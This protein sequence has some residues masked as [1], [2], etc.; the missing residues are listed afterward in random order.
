MATVD[1][2]K[3][4]PYHHTQERSFEELCY[5]IAKGLYGSEGTFTSVDDT[6]GGD[7]VEF[8]L[9]LPNGDDWGW[10]AKFYNPEPRLSVRNRK[11]SIKDSLEESC[12]KHLNLKKWIL[13][14]PTNFTTAEQA[15]FK[16]TLLKCVPDGMQVKLEHWQES[17]F[18]DWL[19]QPRFSGKRHYFFGE[20]VLTLDWCQIQ[21]E[22]QLKT[23]GDKFNPLLHT[24]SDVDDA[25]HQFLGD[26]AFIENFSHQIQELDN[27]LKK[28]TQAVAELN[29]FDPHQIQLNDEK[30]ELLVAVI[31]LNESLS[32]AV[33]YLQHAH[34]LLQEHK[35]EEIQQSDWNP[36]YDQMDK[37]YKAYGYTS[38]AFDIDAIPYTGR[39]EE[40]SSVL[41][42]ARHIIVAPHY[43]AAT[44]MDSWRDVR[45]RLDSINTPDLHVLGHAGVGKTHI[46]SHICQE[47]IDAGL[48]ALLL[49]GGSFTSDQP[50]TQQLRTILDIPPTYS[51][52]DFLKSMATFAEAYHTR[53]PLIIDGLNEAT[54]NGKFSSVWKQ[55]LES[56]A[57][58]I[59]Q[60]TNDL[61][62]IT[63]CRETY[64]SAIWSSRISN[65]IYASGF[66]SYEVEDAVHKYFDYYK[67]EANLTAAPLSQFQHPIYLKIFCETKNSTRQEEKY[68]YIG[69][70]T[71]FEVFEEYLIQCNEA[72]CKRLGL[73]YNAQIVKPTL[74]KM[75]EYL[76]RKNSRNIPQKEL[77]L[78]ADNQPL[79]N[80]VWM[81]SKT[82]AIESEGL[83][84]CRDWL[85]EEDVVNFTY[86][87]LGG[88]LIAQYLIEQTNDGI[89]DFIHSDELISKLLG[90]DYG[91]LHP[92]HEDI[93]R[94]FAALLPSQKGL[95]LHNL[96]KNPKAW[97]ASIEAVF[98]ISP[99]AINQN[100]VDFIAKLFGH[101]K[102]RQPLIELAVSTI[103]HANHPL[104]ATFWSAQFKLLSVPERDLSWTE[105]VRKEVEW[106]T[107][108]IAHF[109]V[110]CKG[111]ETL[112]SRAE[113]HLHLLAQHVMWVLTSTVRALRYDA[114]QALYWYGRRFPNHLLSL[115][116]DSLTVNDPYISER[117]LA[118]VYGV[119]M[120]R[121]YDFKDPGFP[122]VFLPVYGRKLYEAM[123]QPNAP[124]STTHI[125]SR[126]YARHTIEI[127]LIHQPGLL[128]D[129]ER[130]RIIP[131]F[132]DGGI[133]KWGKSEDKNKG[134][135]KDGNCPF[136]YFDDP[137]SNL[138]EG[139]DKYHD[140][141]P[142][143]KL[144]KSNLW[145]RIYK[146]GYSQEAFGEVDGWINRRWMGGNSDDKRW[147]YHYGKKYCNI[148]VSELAGYREDKGLLKYKW[149]SD[150]KRSS[151]TDI[152][153][154]FPEPP[155]EIN[156]FQSDLLGDRSLPIHEWI[157]GGQ[158]PDIK[159]FLQV[160]DF[161]GIAG[162]WVMLSGIV[163]QTENESG[164][165][166]FAHI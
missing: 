84:V 116:L 134:N 9:T 165:N 26:A 47:R 62:L 103:D 31:P 65:T 55:D 93:R 91:K 53:I 129:T 32:N 5:Q 71:L 66:D 60:T 92:L 68:L 8:Y 63:T 126:D 43:L 4:Q 94:C 46:A 163:R 18:L 124:C 20:L 164:R 148:A 107:E 156:I 25:I 119:A 14:T 42:Q 117:M 144:A 108:L 23:I 106:F 153:P 40:K 99:T 38:A 52:N 122:L 114:T 22:K 86:D 157:V 50:L 146:L 45:S 98:E 96:T 13:C 70:E 35:F 81:L 72:V 166:I 137:M 102:S 61:A 54:H 1:W 88:Y 82:Q 87:L 112:S 64:R 76:W 74:Y 79:E 154:S 138:G 110:D 15:W 161:A 128:N 159:P 73:K 155:Q 149:E 49:R 90:D 39:Q 139:I 158:V 105:Y 21:L 36:I 113:A 37:T 118:T 11:Q 48:P 147:T 67:I 2:S 27:D 85:G 133:R 121:Q 33:A 145:W 160:N 7:G 78:I 58:E 24:E 136:D 100:C 41:N 56:L 142:Q 152:D 125:L 30:K 115:A 59:G 16:N 162:A 127:A 143:Y 10:Q 69:E 77:V 19:S 140:G 123:F 51:W 120:A 34:T 89:E 6:G 12:K 109:E 132:K 57:N 150:C 130:K 75:A 28:H 104:N 151:H 83:L 135:Y 3:L 101:P 111:T 80:L 131:P 95:Y 141:T 29:S 97:N 44:F 17:D